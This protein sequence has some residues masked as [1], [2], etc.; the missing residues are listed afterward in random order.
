MF[1]Q[2]KQKWAHIKCVPTVASSVRTELRK[3]VWNF[4]RSCEKKATAEKRRQWGGT[5]EQ[6]ERREEEE[7]E[8]TDWKMRSLLAYFP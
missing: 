1:S 3:I 4:S 6:V 8:N 2:K 5:R 7:G